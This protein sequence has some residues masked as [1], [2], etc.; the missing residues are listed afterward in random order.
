VKKVLRLGNDETISEARGV[1]TE[2][3]T[4]AKH[5]EVSL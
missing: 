3:E 4:C 1:M 2:K 5:G